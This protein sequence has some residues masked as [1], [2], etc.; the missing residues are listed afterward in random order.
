MLPDCEEEKS[1]LLLATKVGQPS[2]RQ[3]EGLPV[4]IDENKEVTSDLKI[5][6]TTLW[7]Q[8]LQGKMWQ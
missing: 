6:M 1:D 8:E 2:D 7:R 5:Y 3:S 4:E